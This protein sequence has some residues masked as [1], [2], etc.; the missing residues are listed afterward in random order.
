M[1]QRGD[2][3]D[4]TAVHERLARVLR[5]AV[6][7]L[8][9]PHI[10]DGGPAQAGASTP[11]SVLDAMPPGAGR[12]LPVPGAG[13][14]TPEPVTQVGPT[15]ARALL[16]GA[17]DPGRRGV[18]ALGVVAVVVVA[19][20]AVLA[21]QARPRVEPVAAPAGV[22]SAV[23]V[24]ASPT[25]V[26]VAV[27][28]RV[29]RPG[30][31]SLPAGARVADAIVAAGGALPGTDLAFVNLARRVTDGELIV[32]G[33]ALPPGAGGPAGAQPVAGAPVNL[34]TATLAQLDQLPG[35]GPV[36]AQRILDYRTAHGGFRSVA[37][38]RQVDGVGDTRYDQLKSLVTV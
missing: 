28:G 27:A 29:R 1:W 8:A 36:L 3:D 16:A 38:L 35:V 17:M 10:V 30:L 2:S 21:W 23:A 5:A 25:A 37:E 20:A 33:V 14:G 24:M 31:V 26:V 15:S 7:A 4:E 22:T 13:H 11:V 18:R 9:E 6:P 32:V 34:N 12:G 19:G